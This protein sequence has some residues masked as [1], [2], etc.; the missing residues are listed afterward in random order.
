MA[1]IKQLLI[2]TLF[3]VI[4]SQTTPIKKMGR[5]PASTKNCNQ[6]A[7]SILLKESYTGLSKKDLTVGARL[8]LDEVNQ[9]IKVWDREFHFYFK[10]HENKLVDAINFEQIHARFKEHKKKMPFKYNSIF[11]DSTF[12][13][14]YPQALNKSQEKYESLR[15]TKKEQIQNDQHLEKLIIETIQHF[16]ILERNYKAIDFYLWLKDNHKLKINSLYKDENL[17][18]FLG[19]EYVEFAPFVKDNDIEALISKEHLQKLEREIQKEREIFEKCNSKI[20]CLIAPLNNIIKKKSYKHF[21]CINRNPVAKTVMWSEIRISMA[22][23]GLM[24]YLNREDLDRFPW[25][26][27]ANT[28]TISPI[29]TEFFCRISFKSKNLI[30]AKWEN[31]YK[32]SFLGADLWR[33]IKT[34]F[35]LS[36]AATVMYLSYLYFFDWAYEQAGIPIENK[37][38][39]KEHLAIFPFMLFYSSTIHTLR[40]I[41]IMNP[42]SFKGIPHLARKIQEIFPHKN[43]EKQLIARLNDAFKYGRSYW[44]SYEI[45]VLFMGEFVPWLLEM[46]GFDEN[47]LPTVEE[48]EVSESSK[49]IKEKVT[50]NPEGKIITRIDIEIDKKQKQAHITNFEV[51]TD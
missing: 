6:A 17:G 5:M 38:S 48:S 33:N 1:Y 2:F 10:E 14:R 37:K 35:K 47:K 8:F 51:V 29:F 31:Q 20:N 7:Q 3:F 28:L 11:S 34:S 43:I 21:S 46:L 44:T 15:I 32:N 24:G 40:N 4:F 42:I 39:L 12:Q 13:K 45:T 22:M 25:E 19:R 49:K 36:S 23:V 16:R 30:G 41:Y 26:L 27:L 18:E 9:E 50:V